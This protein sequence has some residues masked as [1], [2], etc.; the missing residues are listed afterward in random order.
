VGIAAL[1]ETVHRLLFKLVQAYYVDGLTQ[2]EIAGRFGISQP[3]VSRMLQQGREKGVINITLV[4]PPSGAI[5]LERALERRFGLEEVIVVPVDESDDQP[6]V[7]RKLG[8]SKP[9]NRT[10]RSQKHLPLPFGLSLF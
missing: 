1:D 7:A 4:A 2:Q 6:E 9:S 5:D 8:P 10:I 3:K